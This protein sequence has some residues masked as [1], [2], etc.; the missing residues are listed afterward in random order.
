MSE[1]DAPTP[2]APAGDAN[3]TTPPAATAEVQL[4]NPKKA[5]SEV[6]DNFTTVVDVGT[7]CD[8][9]PRYRPKM[10]D[11]HIALQWEDDTVYFGIYDGHGGRGAVDYVVKHLHENFRNQLKV[12]GQSVE[13]AYQK[14]YVETDDG[15]GAANIQFSGTTT[16]SAFIRKEEGKWIL[17]TANVGDARIVLSQNGVAKRLTYDH[18][19][20]DEGEVKRIQEA[21]GFVVYNRV[22]GILAVTR[23]LGDRAMK[24]YVTGDPYYTK[25]ELNPAE[26]KFLVLA[27][28]GVWDVIEDQ[29]C[30]DLIFADKSLTAQKMSERILI[31]SLRA[32][33]TDNISVMVVKLF[34]E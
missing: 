32:G 31:K 14:S 20:S 19:A 9:N 2:A 10:E 7:A 17:H 5:Q 33:S 4:R 1:P 30:L 3:P 18:K 22:N 34:P 8:R 16:V 24:E 25:T 11:A 12:E 6:H 21:G 28:D 29:E 15:V 27:C 23:S 13:E 26:D